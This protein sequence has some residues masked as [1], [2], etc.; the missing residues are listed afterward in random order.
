MDDK[1][2]QKYEAR[3]QI[4]KALAHPT[5]LYLAELL[6]QQERCVAELTELV[7]ADQSTVSRHLA[8]LQGAGLVTYRK[9]GTMNVYR[10]T[11]GCLDSFFACIENVMRVNLDVQRCALG[12]PCS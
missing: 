1:L 4:A 10:V 12:D 6:Q 8:I 2:L 5:R 7:G 3:A 9:A 11:C